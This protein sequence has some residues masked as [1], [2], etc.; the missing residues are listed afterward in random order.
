MAKKKLTYKELIRMAEAYGVESNP[1]FTSAAER[2]VAMTETIAMLR[3]DINE[4]GVSVSH[5]NVKGEENIDVNPL[6]PQLPKYVDTANK[7]LSAMLEV[8]Q[9]AGKP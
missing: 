2:Y 3:E 5:V 6:V 7:T 1:L 4:R 8:I 9:K